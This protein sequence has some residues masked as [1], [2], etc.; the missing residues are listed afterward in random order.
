MGWE[1]FIDRHKLLGPVGEL[2]PPVISIS[3][4]RTLNDLLRHYLRDKQL[5]PASVV[6]YEGVTALTHKTYGRQEL[7]LKKIDRD[8]LMFFRSA[9]LSRAKPV[10]WNN[11]LR[12]LNALL[13]YAVKQEYIRENPCANLKL[14]VPVP[15]PLDK[16]LDIDVIKKVVAYLNTHPDVIPPNWFWSIV[17]RFLYYTGMR[18]TQICG[19]NWDDINFT[20]DTIL[21]RSDH[22]KNLR[23]WAIPIPS[24]IR[25]ELLEL[26][27]RSL[28]VNPSLGSLDQ[29]FNIKLFNQRYKA[30]RLM[31]EHV[32]RF[33]RRLSDA[34]GYR[35]YAHRLRHTCGTQI[36]RQAMLSGGSDPIALKILQEY[37]GHQSIHTT[38]VYL[39][40]SM[41]D[42][43]RMVEMLPKI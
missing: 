6:A 40:P 35:L 32:T 27:T 41:D 30:D 43:A 28:A 11:Y 14:K 36:M 17:F 29:V 21:L 38:S 4:P 16:A 42:F 19:L 5:R 34:T 20:A 12:H 7:L 24:M 8:F 31:E 13:S 2:H 26:Q 18:R 33:F 15:R 25:N 1:Q 39:H 37:F 23:Q 22:S 9:V 3:I 10:T